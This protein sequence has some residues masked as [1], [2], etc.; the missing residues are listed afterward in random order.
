MASKIH[1]SLLKSEAIPHLISPRL[2]NPSNNSS[3]NHH[4][5]GFVKI[6]SS[7]TSSPMSASSL[8]ASPPSSERIN[9]SSS[10]P[11]NASNETSLNTTPNME[12][13]K[14]SFYY[15][16]HQNEQL[17]IGLLQQMTRLNPNQRPSLKKI[18]LIL[19]VL[20]K[21]NQIDQDICETLLSK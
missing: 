1:M 10:T 19:E 14:K 13:L 8:L 9:P 16:S 5:D 11:F 21:Y 12:K 15:C 20:L 3:I 2:H 6:S 18:I 7:E 17:L 4:S